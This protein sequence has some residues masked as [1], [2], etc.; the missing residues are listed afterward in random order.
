M[1]DED[2]IDF[3]CSA[4]WLDHYHSRGLTPRSSGR[5]SPEFHALVKILE[6]QEK[7][8]AELENVIKDVLFRSDKEK[9]TN[10]VPTKKDFKSL[11]RR[12]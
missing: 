3:P 12:E 1:Q 8:F 5:S 10:R 7:R 2:Y 11:L 6:Q 4:D 9:P